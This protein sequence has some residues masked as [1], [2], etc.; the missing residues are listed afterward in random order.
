M[1]S[2][3]SPLNE[4]ALDEDPTKAPPLQEPLH[5]PRDANSVALTVLA[6]SAVVFVLHWAQAIFISSLIVLART[7]SAPRKI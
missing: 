2:G 5:S 4:D 7:S 1:K 3:L 6:V